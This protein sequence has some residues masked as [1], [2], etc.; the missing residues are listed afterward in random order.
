VRL[1]SLYVDVDRLYC[2]QQIETRRFRSPNHHRVTTPAD[3]GD[4]TPELP[5]AKA[6]FVRGWWHAA[7][8]GSRNRYEVARRRVDSYVLLLLP[9][10]QSGRVGMYWGASTCTARACPVSR[11]HDCVNIYS[12]LHA[13]AI[14]QD[15]FDWTS[16]YV[17]IGFDRSDDHAPN[18]NPDQER[19]AS[20][21]TYRSQL[22]I[23]GRS[24][25]TR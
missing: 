15:P 1:G 10:L 13:R 18:N 5:R 21:R 25:R 7:M 12:I 6:W 24:R 14:S 22:T 3:D 9:P 17:Y 8:F 16:L 4:G 20:P 19:P 2:A 23:D 11:R